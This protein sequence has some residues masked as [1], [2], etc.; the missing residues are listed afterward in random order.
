M[1]QKLDECPACKHTLLTNYLICEDHAA[2]G[3]SFAL[4]QCKKCSLVIIN[5]RPDQDHIGAYYQHNDYI[6]HTNQANNPVNWLYK[7]V[8]TITLAQKTT[9]IKSHSDQKRILDFGCGT[10]L[11]I[12][13]L[14]KNG[15]RPIGFEP[16]PNARTTAENITGLPILNDLKQLEQQKPFDII[17]A[18]HVLEHVHDLRPTLKALRKS[19][20]EDGLMFIALPNHLS[21]DAKHYGSHWAAYDVPRHLSHFN[22]QSLEKLA[23]EC[24]LNLIKT[25][26]MKF[27]AYYVSLLSEKYK[28]G[29]TNYLKALRVGLK[30]NQQARQT[31]EY[32]SLI[33]VLTK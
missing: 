28:T 24:K 11:F 31:S 5:P 23:K 13:H 18:W 20:N 3:E 27:D 30:S 15:F 2:S 22:Q 19:L 29:K 25:Y 32:S 12:Q 8:R 6:S 17:T 26:P 21:F 10:G 14:K 4:V 7:Q 1:Y 33:Y 9:L 16:S